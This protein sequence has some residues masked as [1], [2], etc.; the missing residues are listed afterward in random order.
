MGGP[1][2]PGPEDLHPTPHDLD[3]VKRWGTILDIEFDSTKYQMFFESMNNVKIKKYNSDS[4]RDKIENSDII[5]VNINRVPDQDFTT[6]FWDNTIL[7]YVY[8]LNYKG[9]SFVFDQRL[10]AMIYIFMYKR[11]P[12]CLWMSAFISLRI[13]LPWQR[14]AAV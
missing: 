9:F 2:D 14:N 8:N 10:F 6:K 12:R 1:R 3:R 7:D 11:V 13:K 4:N 5:N